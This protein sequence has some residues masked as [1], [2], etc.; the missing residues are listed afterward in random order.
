[1]RP[2]LLPLVPTGAHQL[3][4][5]AFF[6]GHYERLLPPAPQTHALGHLCASPHR[7]TELPVREQPKS[8]M[9]AHGVSCYC[10]HELEAILKTQ[11]RT[12]TDYNGTLYCQQ[13]RDTYQASLHW[14]V[15]GTYEES[16]HCIWWGPG[17]ITKEQE[18]SQAPISTSSLTERELNV[19]YCLI[20]LLP[21]QLYPQITTSNT[22]P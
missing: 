13:P 7:Q 14:C 18:A 6:P 10:E 11:L 12:C 19:T 9:L 4:P 5:Q 21:G 16:P 15:Q 2:H 22:R 1:M 8:R 20:F 17:R 3:A